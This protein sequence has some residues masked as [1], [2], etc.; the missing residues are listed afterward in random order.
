MRRKNETTYT[1]P[2]DG[3]RAVS[4]DEFFAA[5]GGP[6]NIHPYPHR[7]QTFWRVVGTHTVVGWTSTGYAGPFEHENIPEI[8]AVAR[9]R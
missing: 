6:R 3:M 2:P 9:R 8:Y 7:R 5:M 4:R 1:E